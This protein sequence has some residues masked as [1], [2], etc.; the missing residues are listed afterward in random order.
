MTL[1]EKAL[2][3]EDIQEILIKDSHDNI[4]YIRDKKM[5]T[6]YKYDEHGNRIYKEDQSGMRWE[7]E[8]DVN[9]NR[10][11]TKRSDGFEGRFYYDARGNMVVVQ[12]SYDGKMGFEEYRE[13]DDNNRLVNNIMVTEDFITA[14]EYDK[15]GKCTSTRKQRQEE[16]K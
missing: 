6:F 15:N 10:I 12:T 1:L 13:Y 4:I 16:T 14:Y 8:N 7:Y 11:Y 2:D 3:A 9:G 5:E